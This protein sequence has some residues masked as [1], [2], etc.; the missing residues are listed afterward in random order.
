MR[1]FGAAN[2][3]IQQQTTTNN[4]DSNIDSM[5]KSSFRAAF[6]VNVEKTLIEK[7]VSCSPS[8]GP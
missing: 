5:M 4:R 8:A 2:W 6:V 3:R 7:C 1:F